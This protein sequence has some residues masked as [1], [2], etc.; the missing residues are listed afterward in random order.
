MIDPQTIR[1]HRRGKSDFFSWQLY[2]WIKN[3]P[4][5]HQIWRG[6][7]NSA[8]G[9]DPL[10]RPLYIGYMDTDGYG[11]L[12]LHGRML[13]S[14]CLHGQSIDGIAYG[15]RHDTANWQEITAEWWQEYSKRGVC[16]IHGDLA[17]GEW[18]E[19]GQGRGSDAQQ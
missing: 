13:R 17:K 18:I 10:E 8:T 15:P 4:Y 16:A 5:A 9:I 12:W 2:R 7:W 6:T 19:R 3:R 1:P 11:S 14:L